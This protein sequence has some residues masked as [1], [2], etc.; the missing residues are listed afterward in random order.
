MHVLKNHQSNTPHYSIPSTN[1]DYD[2]GLI[3]SIF[4]RRCIATP[5]FFEAT[6]RLAGSPYSLV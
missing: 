2:L 1:Q 3:V 4:G 6:D 5:W